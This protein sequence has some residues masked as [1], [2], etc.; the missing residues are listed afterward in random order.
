MSDI[1]N[2]AFTS[3]RELIMRHSKIDTKSERPSILLNLGHACD[4]QL[5]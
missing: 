2:Q 1:N 5:A 4:W 3:W